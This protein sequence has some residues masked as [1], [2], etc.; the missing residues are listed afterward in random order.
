MAAKLI[1]LLILSLTVNAVAASNKLDY[2]TDFRVP[3]QMA[4]CSTKTNIVGNGTY[5]ECMLYVEKSSSKCDKITKPIFDKLIQDTS[6]EV[7]V[8][9]NKLK[10]AATNYQACLNNNYKYNK[11]SNL[12]HKSAISFHY[13]LLSRSS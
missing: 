8:F 7:T 2:L 3:T 4:F 9:V 12:T 11:S 13:T 10:A 1:T 5:K 6:V